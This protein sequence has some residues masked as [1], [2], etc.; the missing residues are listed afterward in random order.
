MLDFYHLRER[1]FSLLPNPRSMYLS[2]Q[3]LETK[4]KVLYYLKDR[5]ASLYL[6][7]PIGCGKTSGLRCPFAI[8]G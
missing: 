3:Y 6:Y 2:E 7:G 8:S 5:S 1:P 4:V